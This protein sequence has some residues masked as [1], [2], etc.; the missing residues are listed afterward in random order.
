MTEAAIGYA[1]IYEIFDTTVSPDAYTVLGEVTNIEPASDSIDQEDVTHMASPNRRREFIAGLI[2][3]GE[4]TVEFNFV[5]G[6]A[7]DI[8]LRAHMAAGTVANHR[9]T[10]PAAPSTPTV[11]H[12]LVVPCFITAY[13]RSAPL[14]TKMVATI[15][16]KRSG[17]ETWDTAP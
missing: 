2:D 3:G 7:T 13:N 4:A 12:R 8:L 17:D 16:L 6:S 1:T 11:R 10:F 5:P 14:A 9:I 15:T